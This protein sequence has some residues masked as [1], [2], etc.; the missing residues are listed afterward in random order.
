[1]RKK[2]LR[3]KLNWEEEELVFSLSVSALNSNGKLCVIT[4]SG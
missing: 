1:M 2:D 4:E 3:R